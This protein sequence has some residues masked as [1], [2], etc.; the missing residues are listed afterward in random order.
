MTTLTI[1]RIDGSIY[2]TEYFNDHSLAKTWLSAEM[3]RPYWDKTYTYT[4]FTDPPQP[5]PDPAIEI[6]KKAKMDFAREYLSSF[7]YEK[8]DP[9]DLPEILQSI[10]LI[11]G[12]K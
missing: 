5:T 7:D 1:K 10:I 3:S 11:M 9:N 12:L 8:Y 4:I 6:E 2:W